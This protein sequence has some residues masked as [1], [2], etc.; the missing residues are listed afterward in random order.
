[1]LLYLSITGIT[2][3]LI[4][5]YFNARKYK[6][7]NYLSIFFFL[8]SLYGIN[9]YALIYSGSVLLVSLI[10]TNITFLHYLIGPMLYFYIRS[11]IR[12]KSRL[13]KGDFVHFIPSAIYLMAALPYILSPYSHKVEIAKS[14]VEVPGFLMSYKVTILS[15]LLSVPFMY[16]SRPLSVSLYTLWSIGMFILYLARNRESN[17]INLKSCGFFEFQA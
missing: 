6:S 3:S 1:M 8:I 17:G 16:L 10:Y 7:S 15:D 14:L 5:F 13:T 4:L 9:Q 12:D 2:L 11:I